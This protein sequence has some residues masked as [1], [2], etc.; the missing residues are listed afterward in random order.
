MRTNTKTLC[1][2]SHLSLPSTSVNSPVST[3]LSCVLTLPKSLGCSVCILQRPTDRSEN[4]YISQ[5]GTFVL[6]ADRE[7]RT[8]GRGTPAHELELRLR[9]R[10]MRRGQIWLPGEVALRRRR[11]G[12]GGGG[13]EGGGGV[14]YSN[15]YSDN[16]HVVY[17]TTFTRALLHQLPLCQL[18][19]CSHSISLAKRSN[20]SS[21]R[22]RNGLSSRHR[23]R[24]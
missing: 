24:R 3:L 16:I 9:E 14:R 19:E 12:G 23:S 20:S 13:E 21:S 17:Q 18:Q 4:R 5:N 11:G 15:V 22:S 8:R 1:V 6:L 10:K 2:C 7:A